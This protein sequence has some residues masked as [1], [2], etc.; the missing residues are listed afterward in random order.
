MTK[1]MLTLFL[2]AVFFSIS[3]ALP[4]KPMM[5]SL[6]PDRMSAMIDASS[7]VLNQRGQSFNLVASD[8][9]RSRITFPMLAFDDFLLEKSGGITGAEQYCLVAETGSSAAVTTASGAQ[10]IM[11]SVQGFLLP[12]REEIVLG[13]PSA[14]SAGTYC[15]AGKEPTGSEEVDSND[16]VLVSSQLIE[17]TPTGGWKKMILAELSEHGEKDVAVKQI[18]R[19]VKA[20]SPETL[21][22][23]EEQVQ[24]RVLAELGDDSARHRIGTLTASISLVQTV[25]GGS[26][27]GGATSGGVTPSGGNASN[28]SNASNASN[29]SGVTSGVTSGGFET[30]SGG[31][32]MSNLCSEGY[33]N[34][35]A[36]FDLISTMRHFG[37]TNTRE[38]CAE[39]CDDED[40]CAVWVWQ[41]PD[42]A[43][44]TWTVS[45]PN[46]VCDDPSPSES[47][48]KGDGHTLEQCK[49]MC[50]DEADCVAIYGELSDGESGSCY[51]FPYKCDAVHNDD[52]DKIY[53]LHRRAGPKEC[54]WWTSN[55]AGDRLQA[56]SWPEQSDHVS[57][58]CS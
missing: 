35:D 2:V 37:E 8:S 6:H 40:T 19:L 58:K 46:K 30:T 38:E 45:G 48:Y 55:E 26:Q 13:S 23:M 57:G 10:V 27:A 1:E 47:R 56:D 7:T 43:Y 52:N 41:K 21:V 49:T 42:T 16:C 44:E 18:V 14:F 11:Q 15:C 28:T 33:N 5:R 3:C 25:S 31:V 9:R 24:P 50:V 54:T 20:S 51:T 17:I 39:K 12:D 4:T 29:I 53:H 32:E 22:L 36:G 34:K